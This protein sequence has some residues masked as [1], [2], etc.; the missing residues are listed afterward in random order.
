MCSGRFDMFSVL[1]TRFVV[2]TGYTDS[3]QSVRTHRSKEHNKPQASGDVHVKTHQS[4]YLQQRTPLKTPLKRGHRRDTA[5]CS[6]IEHTE[7][8]VNQCEQQTIATA[9]N[10]CGANSN[11]CNDGLH[12]LCSSFCARARMHDHPRHMHGLVF[13]PPEKHTNPGREWGHLT[14]AA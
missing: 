1:S 3:V 12:S 14:K 5:Q 10:T 2:S 11:A 9:N 4:A 13:L 7:A 8:P 6:A